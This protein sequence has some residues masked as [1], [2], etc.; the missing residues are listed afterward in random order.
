MTM[1]TAGLG[2]LFLGRQKMR[3]ESRMNVHSLDPELALLNQ[4][5]SCVVWRYKYR[6]LYL[7]YLTMCATHFDDLL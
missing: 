6:Y 4:Q 7:Q 1:T 5:M 2:L 3:Q